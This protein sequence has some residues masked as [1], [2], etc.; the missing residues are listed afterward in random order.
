MTLDLHKLRYVVAVARE[1]S[2]TTAA[3]SLHISQSALTRSVQSLEREFGLPIFERSRTGARLTEAGAEFITAAESLLKHSDSVSEELR[4]IASDS[5]QARIRIGVGAISALEFLPELLPELAATGLSVHVTVETNSRLTQMLSN[6]EIDF[7]VGGVPKNSDNFATA[8]GFITHRILG[9][10]VD[11]LARA[12]HPLV[13]A[14]ITPELLAEYPVAGGSFLTDTLT[15]GFLEGL[16]LQR[17]TV[18]S[19]DYGLL[20]ALARTTDYI[21]IGMKLLAQ[22]RPELG[23]VALPIQLPSPAD[24]QWVIQRSPHLGLSGHAEKVF[25]TVREFITRALGPMQ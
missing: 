1:G 3:A 19:N 15:P 11:L 8:Q 21:I 23:L 13:H 22:R 7:F 10:S 16:G 4:V 5:R 24:T 25:D 6:G 2:F 12:E 14:E 20:C 9:G 18:E 17:P